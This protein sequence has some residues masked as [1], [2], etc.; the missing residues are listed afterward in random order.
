MEIKYF[1]FL[2][3]SFSL[4][5]IIGKESELNTN[6]EFKKK[7]SITKIIL[8]AKLPKPTAWKLEEFSSY[9][10][11]KEV[12]DLLKEARYEK[13]YDYFFFIKDNSSDKDT[14][15]KKKKM[16]YIEKYLKK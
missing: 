1:V 10:Q 13:Y 9:F 3:L 2:I 14:T 6:E 8:D 7:D 15:S 4:T 11:E 5:N 16:Y 12:Y